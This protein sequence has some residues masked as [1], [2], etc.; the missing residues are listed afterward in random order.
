[1]A[2][3][4]FPLINVGKP[5]PRHNWFQTDLKCLLCDPGKHFEPDLLYSTSVYCMKHILYL[6]YR[7]FL[8]I[9]LHFS[10]QGLIFNLLHTDGKVL[11]DFAVCIWLMMLLQSSM[12]RSYLAWVC[13]MC[14][15]AARPSCVWTPMIWPSRPG[16]DSNGRCPPML[17]PPPELSCCCCRSTCVSCGLP[18]WLA[19]ISSTPPMHSAPVRRSWPPPLLSVAILKKCRA[20]YIAAWRESVNGRPN[21]RNFRHISNSV[22]SKI[23]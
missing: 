1:M 15:L 11:A 9:T 14:M 22:S 3:S 5:P 19:G 12:W 7:T 17:A 2:V 13:A 21:G 10:V 23:F 20:H 18:P 8:C 16:S 6:K 4:F